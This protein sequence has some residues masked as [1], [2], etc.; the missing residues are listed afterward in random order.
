[1]NKALRL[2]FR[3]GGCGLIGLSAALMFSSGC[4]ASPPS[5]DLEKTTESRGELSVA[6][7]PGTPS[8]LSKSLGGNLL[9][10]I[11]WGTDND[12]DGLV[13]AQENS[14]ADQFRPYL[15]FDTNEI[16]RKPNEPYTFFQVRPID[17]NH[18][19]KVVAIK[20]VFGFEYDG[21]YGPASDCTI[22]S[23]D[24]HPGDLEDVTF[25][26]VST[27]GVNWT[28]DS[29][30][31]WGPVSWSRHQSETLYVS[32]TDLVPGHP[33][34]FIAASKH[35]QHLTAADDDHDS[36]YSDWGCNDNVNGAGAKVL[37]NLTSIGSTGGPYNNLGEPEAHPSSSFVGDL[38]V[39]NAWVFQIC[40]AQYQVGNG[41]P[42]TLSGLPPSAAQYYPIHN[43]VPYQYNAW[44]GGGF[45]SIG[46]LGGKAMRH[47][48]IG[49]VNYS[50][51]D[52]VSQDSPPTWCMDGQL[53]S[54][55]DCAGDY[56]GSVALRCAT[57]QDKV[58]WHTW[59]PYF[60]EEYP[61]QQ[62]CNGGF[63]NAVECSGDNCDSMSLECV[64]LSGVSPQN[65]QWT[66]SVSDEQGHLDFPSGYY[67]SGIRCSGDYCDNLSFYVCQRSAASPTPVAPSLATVTTAPTSEEYRPV[68]CADNQLVSGVFCRGGYCDNIGFK[69]TDVPNAISQS[70][71]WTDFFSEEAPSS[72][73]CSN[74]FAVGVR[75][76]GSYCDDI[77]LLCAQA[78]NQPQSCYWTTATFSDE[79]RDIDFP[80]GYYLAGAQCFG[81]Y[82]DNKTFYL[83]KAAT[84]FTSGYVW[85][86]SLTGTSTAPST[87][88]Y[89]SSGQSNTITQTGTGLYRVDFP[90]LGTEVGGNVQ[91]TA[92]GWGSERCKVSSWG[93]DGSKVSA[94]I[95][96]FDSQGIAVDALFTASYLRATG[97]WPFFN[98]G[99]LWAD[100]PTAASYTPYSTY[101]W[102]SSG[103]NNT[104]QR[105][106]VGSYYATFPGITVNGGTVEVTAYGPGSEYCKVSS[107]GSNV[108]YVNCF[109]SSGQ[110]ADTRF[111]LSFTDQSPHGTPSYAYAWA[112]QPT[113]ASYTPSTYYQKT[114][115]SCYS[116]GPVTIQ[117]TWTGRYT[118]SIPNFII[119]NSGVKVTAYGW[120]PETCKAASWGASNS[121]TQVNIVC[122]DAA[123]NPVD[124]YF[125]FD[126]SNSDT[127]IC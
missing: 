107:W 81:D 118:A 113:A 14:L 55:F 46:S 29:V 93:S 94:N 120:G 71:S 26:V 116:P 20:Y 27:D 100:Q 23:S 115:K 38:K 103:A 45:Y 37:V 8:N 76:L 67:L 85:N 97:P 50:Y 82:C 53:I 126:Y 12:L 61:A 69:C 80:S 108:V 57:T 11:A 28:L 119:D 24:A 117:R 59:T 72:R 63:V 89:S 102:N 112:D 6:P 75:C 125:T 48:M 33:I 73:T 19:T 88:S 99:Y 2:F 104:V 83:C 58:T 42:I 105:I 84:S 5:A 21:G 66:Q 18:A 25:H 4:S 74:G 10:S 13:D 127:T 3:A 114:F 7:Y 40:T 65:C 36:P 49:P 44:D 87:Y 70:A 16:A 41:S 96:C 77:S 51:S 1:M 62:I 101:Q 106:G 92:Y 39:N 43:C 122:F 111:T 56:C 60:S 109:N 78:R 123:G 47:L 110:A 91:V 17:L 98:G 31:T 86:P 121:A 54:G 32:G 22:I 52:F 64:T 124:T 90:G 34:M 79:Q 35:H 95:A 15:F 68:Y 30:Q 9:S